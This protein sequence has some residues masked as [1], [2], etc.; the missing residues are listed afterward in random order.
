MQHAWAT[1]VETMGT[2]LGQALKS[3]QGD[4]EWKAFFQ[5]ASAS[6]AGL[7]LT[8]TIPGFEGQSQAQIHQ[9]LALQEKELRVLDKLKGFA[10]ATDK[11]HQTRGQGSYHLIILNSAEKTVELRPYPIS[12]LEEANR[13]YAAIETRA[14]SGEPLEAVLVSAGPIEALKKAYPNYFLDTEVFIAQIEDIVRN[15]ASK[16]ISG[17]V[18]T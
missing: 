10:V 13:D 18:K 2:Y 4:N 15:A 3:G 6:L 14:K 17:R 1:A 8:P 16:T 12:R 5:T 7:E 11:I 9:T